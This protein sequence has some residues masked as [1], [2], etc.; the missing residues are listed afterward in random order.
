MT[1]LFIRQ[2]SIEMISE[3]KRDQSCDRQTKGRQDNHVETIL[4]DVRF[5]KPFKSSTAFLISLIVFRKNIIKPC[6]FALASMI[7]LPL[8][9]LS[10]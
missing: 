3:K 6:T 8:N 5:R 9:Q 2:Y 4:I 1:D 7:K 10:N